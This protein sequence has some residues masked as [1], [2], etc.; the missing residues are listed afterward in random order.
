VAFRRDTL[1][2]ISPHLTSEDFEIETE[3]CIKAKELG[4]K[5]EEVPSFEHARWYGQS[6]LSTFRDGFRILRLI[7]RESLFSRAPNAG[8][9]S[10]C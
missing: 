8:L 7:V 4:I 2:R 10:D 3:I 9:Q 5:V 1:K 6:N